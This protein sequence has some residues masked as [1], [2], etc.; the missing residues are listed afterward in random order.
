MIFSY[1]QKVGWG[2]ILLTWWPW[3]LTYDLGLD[4]LPLYLH[5]KTQVYCNLYVRLFGRESETDGHTD[6]QCQTITPDMS[7]TWAV[8]IHLRVSENKI[9]TVKF[10]TTPPPQ[11]ING[12]PLGLSSGH[13]GHGPIYRLL[14]TRHFT[15]TFDLIVWHWPDLWPQS[16]TLISEQG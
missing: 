2:L 6:R 14:H 3:P 7:E 11:M 1:S 10:H 4:I 13:A 12:R 9:V 5:V 8:N 15:L 16:M